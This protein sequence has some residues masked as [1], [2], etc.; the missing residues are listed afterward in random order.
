MGFAIRL[1]IWLLLLNILINPQ[2]IVTNSVIVGGVTS[3]SAKFWIRISQPADINIEVSEDPSFASVNKGTSV[4]VTPESNF[5]GIVSVSGLKPDTKYFYRVLINDD[6]EE[7]PERYFISFPEAAVNSYFTFAFGSCQQSGPASGGNVYNEIV[8]HEPRFF[9]QIGD[10]GYPDTTDNTPFNNNFFPASYTGVQLSYERKYNPAYP[11]DSLC[12]TAPIDYVYD[13]HDYMNNNASA[14]SSSFSVPIKPNPLG[15][16]FIVMEIPNPLN[17]RENSIR[18]YREN[19]PGYP[20]A[21]E[22]RGIY[23]KF[24]FGNAEFFVLDLRAQRSPNLEAL[25]KNNSSGFWEFNPPQGHTILGRDNA[26]GSGENQMDWFLNGLLNSNADWKFVISSVPF[27]KSQKQAIDL[28]ILLQDL[29]LDVPSDQYPDSIRGIFAAMELADKWAGFHTDIDIVLNFISANNIN[30]VIVLS[31][32]SHTAALDDGTN[33]GLPEIMAGGLDIT[34]SQLAA[35]LAAF[36]LNIWNRGGQGLTTSEF[37][38]AF[39]K[40]SVFGSDSVRLS[41]IDEFGTEFAGYTIINGITDIKHAG[42][43]LLP[44][45]HELSQNFPNPFNPETSI[46]YSIPDAGIVSLKVYDILGK[47]VKTLVNGFKERGRHNIIFNAA[48]IPGGIY[49][50][51]MQTNNFSDVKKMVLLK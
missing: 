8:K 6:P 29:V 51:K 38:N 22:S 14:L 35:I 33:A 44:G 18:G 7:T 12:R 26:P 39:G 1:I 41:L 24:T 42:N 34:N 4:S 46:N 25:V 40:I 19:F 23:H 45:A 47:E 20:P 48:G 21:N 16:D 10:W 27:N 13:D 32:D 11:M 30:N 37:N 3:G 31:G 17:A 49:F 50:Y 5:A 2:I 9:L 36:G 43:N 15:S 28:S